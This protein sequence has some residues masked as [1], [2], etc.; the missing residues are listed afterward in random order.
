MSENQRI[1]L[2]LLK[3][4]IFR[5]GAAVAA[6][7]V[8]GVLLGF[9]YSVSPICLIAFVLMAGAAGVTYLDYKFYKKWGKF[10]DE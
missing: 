4:N 3:K 9:I 6:G 2:L 8:V 7:S 1:I 10:L 5:C